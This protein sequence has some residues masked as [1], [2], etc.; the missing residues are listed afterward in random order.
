MCG[1]QCQTVSAL[2][3]YILYAMTP[4]EKLFDIYH[5]GVQFPNL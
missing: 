2:L 4:A 3:V 5:S 1:F